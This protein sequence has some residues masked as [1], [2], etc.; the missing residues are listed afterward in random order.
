MERSF[1]DYLSFHDEILGDTCRKCNREK[2]KRTNKKL[3]GVE[4]AIQA[5]QFK[6]KQIKTCQERYGVDYVSQSKDFRNKVLG[7][8]REEYGVDNVSQVPEFREKAMLSF[9]Q[10]G[11]CP[12]SQQQIVVAKI[13]EKIYGNCEL[14]KPL[15]WY[16]LDCCVSINGIDIDIE[17]DGWY[18]HK[19][20]QEEDRKR[21][22]YVTKKG[23][24]VLRIITD[25]NKIPTEKEIVNYINTLLKSE[26]PILRINIDMK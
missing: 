25:K 12:T 4:W 18:W 11:T 8:V 22:N 9:Q 2:A 5:Q 7:T 20:K 1:R 14:N 16:S 26:S 15:D 19:N 10:N 21:D 13:L 17:Y 3:Y 24:K 23:Y 6:E